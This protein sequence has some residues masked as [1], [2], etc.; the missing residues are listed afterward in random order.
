MDPET[1]F[2]PIAIEDAEL[3]ADWFAG[4]HVMGVLLG[5]DHFGRCTAMSLKLSDGRTL[6]FGVDNG[7]LVANEEGCGEC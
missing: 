4:V 3:V 6:H 7:C 5:E 1:L 2:Y